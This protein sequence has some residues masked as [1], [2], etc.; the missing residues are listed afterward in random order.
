MNGAPNGTVS[1]KVYGVQAPS[2]SVLQQMV[3]IQRT[4]L[5]AGVSLPQEVL[6]FFKRAP[7]LLP[8]ELVSLGQRVEGWQHASGSYGFD[9]QVANIPDD[10]AILRVIVEKVTP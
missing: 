4:C 7:G 2:A 5:Q 9:I 1:V 6:A 8:G 3:I 10:V